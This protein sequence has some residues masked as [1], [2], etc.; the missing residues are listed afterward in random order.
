MES[1][2]KMVVAWCHTISGEGIDRVGDVKTTKGNYPI[3][4]AYE[5]AVNGSLPGV[6]ERRS[7]GFRVIFGVHRRRVLAEDEW[8]GVGGER[9]FELGDGVIDIGFGG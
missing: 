1:R 9:F 4:G 3:G 5:S 2:G 6:Q 8:C 7:V